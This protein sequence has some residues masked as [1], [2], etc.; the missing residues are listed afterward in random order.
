MEVLFFSS[1]SEL[2][3]WLTENH[4]K[5]TEALIGF[6]KKGSGKS[7][8]TYLE[9]VEQALCFGW[10][11]GV[12]KGLDAESY[13][14]RF[15]PRK[16]KSIWSE[17]NI[18]RVAE[19]SEAGQ[20]H[21]AG[22]KAFEMRT[23]DKMKQYSFENKDAKLDET[24]LET[25]KAKTPAWEFFQAQAPSYQR[26]AVWWVISAKRE[27][28]RQKRLIDLIETSGKSLRL[29]HLVSPGKKPK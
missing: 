13:A 18:K 26:A 8:I 7:G 3:E 19:L 15:T 27:E 24:Q 14:H 11:D 22:I 4:A 12:S 25:F 10:I 20:M 1:P 5:T 17:V 2:R 29:S 28:T 9:A 21:P 16:A 23:A 6:Y